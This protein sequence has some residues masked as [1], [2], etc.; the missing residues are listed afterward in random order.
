MCEH[1]GG[2]GFQPPRSVQTVSA[3]S[4]C[5]RKPSGS[6]WTE[7]SYFCF[8]FRCEVVDDH[9]EMS[10]TRRLTF[11]C[12]STPTRWQHDMLQQGARERERERERQSCL[13][14][15]PLGTFFHQVLYLSWLVKEHSGGLL[16]H[17]SRSPPS[18]SLAT[19]FVS[20]GCLL[21]VC[22]L[23]LLSGLRSLPICLFHEA[24]FT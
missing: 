9:A 11:H 5:Y 16:G 20:P 22:F 14:R 24:Q 1:P 8:A 10:E 12:R 13:P 21:P 6:M 19:L 17:L 15:S 3:C 4:A 2:A 23:T 7:T 18:P